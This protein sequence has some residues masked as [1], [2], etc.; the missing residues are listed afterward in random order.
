[1]H[2][3][4]EYWYTRTNAF[5]SGSRTHLGN[6]SCAQ[7]LVPF[8]SSKAL[9][10]AGNDIC[11]LTDFLLAASKQ[12]QQKQNKNLGAMQKSKNLEEKS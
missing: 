12:K 7:M 4:H 6:A 3:L 9:S 11:E 5:V 8:A 10:T 1:M 2:T